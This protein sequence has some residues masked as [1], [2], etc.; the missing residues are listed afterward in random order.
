MGKVPKF[1]G[2][3]VNGFWSRS[4]KPPG[5]DSP[6]PPTSNR[7]KA[8][9]YRYQPTTIRSFVT[10]VAWLTNILRAAAGHKKSTR[11]LGRIC[12]SDGGV[13]GEERPR[14]DGRDTGPITKSEWPPGQIYRAPP[15]DNGIEYLQTD[16]PGCN[17]PLHCRRPP[18]GPTRPEAGIL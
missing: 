4:E 8:F 13:G 6:P 2:A 7:V 14:A 12:N 17:S 10:R 18:V 11:S 15:N 5:A 3:S 16:Q 1:Y 9:S